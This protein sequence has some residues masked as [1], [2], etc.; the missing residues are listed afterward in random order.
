MSP[1]PH[2]LSPMG[3]GRERGKNLKAKS[4]LFTLKAYQEEFR[5]KENTNVANL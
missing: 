5:V 3:R 2:T 4:K 1:S